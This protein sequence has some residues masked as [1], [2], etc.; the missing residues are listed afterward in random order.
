MNKRIPKG[1]AWKLALAGLCAGVVNGLLGAGGGIVV[2]FA[3]AKLLPEIAS[4]KNGAF[5]TALCVMLPTSVLSTIIYSS[6]GHMSLD[7]FGI[8]ILPAVIGGAVG[9][10]LLGKLGSSILNRLFAALIVVSGII[11]IIR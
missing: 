10:F 1:I 9:G 8:F 3:I 2:V 5:A 4:D 11:L 6:R 7:G